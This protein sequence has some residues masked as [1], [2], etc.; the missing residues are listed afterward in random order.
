MAP[1]SADMCPSVVFFPFPRRV[2]RTDDIDRILQLAIGV[3]LGVL[4][5]GGL[6]GVPQAVEF[7]ARPAATVIK[8]LKASF[9]RYLLRIATA[10]RP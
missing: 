3:V 10:S 7:F 2:R 4:P 5:L 6:F 8:A 1:Q 9:G